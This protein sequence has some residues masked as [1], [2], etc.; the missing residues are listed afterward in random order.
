MF[1]ATNRNTIDF[2]M[3]LCYFCC[4]KL[5]R[6]VV[7]FRN[8]SLSWLTIDMC[9]GHSRR[10]RLLLHMASPHYH[11][12]SMVVHL[13]IRTKKRNQKNCDSLFICSRSYY[14]QLEWFPARISI[15][16]HDKKV[17]HS[18]LIRECHP[19]GGSV[20]PSRKVYLDCQARRYLGC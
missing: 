2:C 15:T 14:Q 19:I 7:L 11:E 3:L 13:V 18:S 1:T 20:K 17:R 12:K 16:C 8:G 10:D 5:P 4:L 6:Q 9:Q